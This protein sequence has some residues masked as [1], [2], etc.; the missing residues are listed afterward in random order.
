M[1]PVGKIKPAKNADE[2]FGRRVAF[3]NRWLPWN[4]TEAG[5]GDQ[6][7]LFTFSYHTRETGKEVAAKLRARPWLAY[8]CS[9]GARVKTYDGLYATVSGI[10]EDDTIEVVLDNTLQRSEEDELREAAEEGAL[11][12]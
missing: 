4:H 8:G 2:P 5:V 7:L 9:V 11:A 6:T 10:R 12:E 3:H 1:M